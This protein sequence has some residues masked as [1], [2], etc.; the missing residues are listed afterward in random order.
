MPA[1]TSKTD[2]QSV[3]LSWNRNNDPVF[4]I[5]SRFPQANVPKAREWNIKL[6]TAYE[7]DT[8]FWDTLIGSSTIPTTSVTEVPSSRLVLTNG[9]SGSAERSLT[10]S[11]AHTFLSRGSLPSSP[12]EMLKTDIEARARTIGYVAVNNATAAAL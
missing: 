3:E 10:I 4:A 9:G 2:V 12:D 5:G 8:D 7:V 11:F 1:G 6:S